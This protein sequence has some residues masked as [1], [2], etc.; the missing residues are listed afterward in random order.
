MEQRSH[1]NKRNT[2]TLN[3]EPSLTQ[4]HLGNECDINTIM[5]RARRGLPVIQNARQAIYGDVSSVPQYREMLD[6]IRHAG[7]QFMLLPAKIR[8]RF[9]NDPVELLRFLEDP[10]NAAEAVSL[11][12]A[13]ERQGVPPAAPT[14]PAE[15]T[16]AQ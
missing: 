2:K 4:Q 14:G 10:T 12:L 6:I 3:S 11:G 9:Q 7:E 13:S 16:P 8:D 1:Q 15:G 5:E